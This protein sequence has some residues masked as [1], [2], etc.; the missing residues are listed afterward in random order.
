MEKEMKNIEFHINKENLE[1]KKIPNLP[2][3]EEG[4]NFLK[5]LPIKIH[6]IGNPS[7]YIIPNGIMEF[8]I[9]PKKGEVIYSG[10]E[11]IKD[12]KIVHVGS[13]LRVFSNKIKT[14]YNFHCYPLEKT[15]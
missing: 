4:V 13:A 2:S 5:E 6:S 15:K 10:F 11:Q 3:L 7:L 1:G 8:Y 14:S 9:Y 12:C